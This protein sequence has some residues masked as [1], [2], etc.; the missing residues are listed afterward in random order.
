MVG[1]LL[2]RKQTGQN[3]NFK[4]R[5]TILIGDQSYINNISTGYQLSRHADQRYAFY[6]SVHHANKIEIL[7]THNWHI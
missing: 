5:Q 7:P 6:F 4:Q 2:Q 1:R 3:L